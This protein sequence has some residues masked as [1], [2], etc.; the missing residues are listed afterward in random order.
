MLQP[1]AAEWERLKSAARQDGTVVVAG[2]GV[3]G[4]R[5]GLTEGFQRA[6]GVG[7]EYLGLPGGEI[8]A[9]TDREAKAGNVTVDVYVGGPGSCWLMGERG[10]IEEPTKLM[11]DPALFDPAVWRGGQMRP[12]RPSPNMPRDFLCGVQTAEWVMTDLFVNPTLVVP[13]AIT[14]WQDLLKPEYK[15]KIASFDPRRAGSSQTT[16]GYLATLFGEPFVRDLYLGQDVQLTAD[17]RQLAEWIARGNYAIGIGLVQATVEPLRAQGL[18]LE[19]VFPAD[20]P[21][22][23]TGGFGTMFRIKGGPHPNAAALFMNWFA[24]KEAQEIWEREMMETSLR[25]DVAHRVPDY[26]IPKPGVSYP[27]DDY[28]PDYYFPNRVPVVDRIIQALGR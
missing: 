9:R 24:S 5:E 25:T 14:S 23:L 12:I 10:Q 26:V 16:V 27:I 20:G 21:G 7:V 11:V 18:P 19:R 28:N 13:E 1:N 8:A 17:Y 2:Q 22:A 6:Y 3:P 4:L 15:G